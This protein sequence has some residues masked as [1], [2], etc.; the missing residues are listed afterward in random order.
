MFSYPQKT[1][2]TFRVAVFRAALLFRSSLENQS[3]MIIDNEYLKQNV[4][5]EKQSRSFVSV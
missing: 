3:I 5:F 1:E 2:L 4:K